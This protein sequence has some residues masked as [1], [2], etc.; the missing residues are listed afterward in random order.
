M[1]YLLSRLTYLEMASVTSAGISFPSKPARSLESEK[2]DWTSESSEWV[3]ASFSL[4]LYVLALV[5]TSF[6]VS[7]SPVCALIAVTSSSVCILR[8]CVSASAHLQPRDSKSFSDMISESELRY[9]E[10]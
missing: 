5:A 3:V 9:V 7:V 2:R 4:V 10:S 8:V 6:L 1:V